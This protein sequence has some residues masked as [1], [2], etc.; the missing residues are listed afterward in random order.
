MSAPSHITPAFAATVH[1]YKAEGPQPLMREIPPGEPYPVEALGPLRAAVEAVQAW[2]QT[3]VAIPAAS[4]LSV[5]AL[6]VQGHADVQTLG[7]VRPLSLYA[8]TIAQSG[9]RKS[10]CDELMLAALAAFQREQAKRQTADVVGWE[11]A[12]ALWKGERDRILAEA[13]KGK[14]EKRIA[15]NADLDALGRA[16]VAPANTERLVGGQSA[17][18]IIRQFRE[19]M[20]SLGL[21]SDEGGKFLGGYAM[22][23]EN[24][25]ATMAAL[26]DAWQ[27]AP[28][29][30][31]LSGE[32]SYT[33]YGRRLSSHLMVQASVARAFMS[34]PM[35]GDI[36]LLPRFLIC[37]P[38]TTMGTRFQSRV[39]EDPQTIQAFGGRLTELL[40]TPLPMDPETRE[41]QPRVIPLA[42]AA[43]AMLAGYADHVE[44][45]LTRGGEFSAIPGHASKSA[46]QAARIAGVM[47]AWV[48]LNAREVAPQTMADAITLAQ[49][50]LSEALRLNDA[51]NIS[52]EVER[53]EALRKWLLNT[54]QHA[55]IT[56]SEV[57]QRAPIRALREGPAARAAIAMLERYGWLQRLPEGTVARGA[58]RKDLFSIVR[59]QDEI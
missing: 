2:K 20:P 46:E 27:G 19:G 40:E 28:I 7:G 26:N 52:T 32:G 15:A 34:D 12:Y 17:Q 39:R 47:T 35:A 16:P 45:G 31:S 42:P 41:L 33:L 44:A 6:A 49:F 58:A 10:S 21:F 24:R 43:R 57:T 14:G 55:D 53:A 3:P 18:G 36:G 4:A 22:Q 29:R 50:Y 13:R 54:W 5:A 38:E 56:P 8:L 59:P 9:E 51:A 48:D 25:M 1:D 37:D 23:S 30:V 11:N